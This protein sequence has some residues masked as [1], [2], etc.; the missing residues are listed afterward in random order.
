[1]IALQRLCEIN[2]ATLGRLLVEDVPPL[3]TLERP[4]LGNQTRVSC[5]P[6]GCYTCIPH[7]WRGGAR[8]RSVWELE[9]VPDRSG[10]LFHAGNTVADTEGCIL[11]GRGLIAVEGVRL[12]QSRDAIEL[13]RKAIGEN[14]FDLTI[15]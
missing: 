12:I 9:D 7:G 6:T 3:W 10:I 11:V 5:V 14:A 4:W 2:G 1:L 8:F 15:S 13:M